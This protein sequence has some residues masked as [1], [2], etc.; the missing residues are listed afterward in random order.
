VTLRSMI[1]IIDCLA[2]ARTA[3]RLGA[4]PGVVFNRDNVAQGP[5]SCP[6]ITREASAAA[7][8]QNGV[9]RDRTGENSGSLPSPSGFEE[10]GLERDATGRY[11]FRRLWRW[12]C[13]M[14]SV[15]TIPARIR[16]RFVGDVL[17]SMWARRAFSSGACEVGFCMGYRAFGRRFEV[18]ALARSFEG[19]SSSILLIA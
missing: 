15:V 7:K 4:T 9:P 6:R 14:I 17:A 2:A 3:A 1:E 16:S 5:R 10:A 12:T 13:A 19:I 18:V 8:T 11:F